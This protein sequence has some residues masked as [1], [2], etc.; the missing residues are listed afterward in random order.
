MQRKNG[1]LLDKFPELSEQIH[2]D[3]IP[4]KTEAA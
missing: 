2:F 3:P 1:G 4:H